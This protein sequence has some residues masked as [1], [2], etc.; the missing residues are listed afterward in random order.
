MTAPAVPVQRSSS[1]GFVPLLRGE[2][3]DTLVIDGAGM[4][5]PPRTGII[6]VAGED[7][8][9]QFLV[10]WITGDYESRISPGTS[11]RI[12]KHRA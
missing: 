5:G 6:T 2:P 12:E 8:R 9:P 3:G 11:A 4:S 1:S 10:R 7:G